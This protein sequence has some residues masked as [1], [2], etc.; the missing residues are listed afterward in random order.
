MADKESERKYWTRQDELREER[1]QFVHDAV[2]VGFT[3]EQARFL[4]DKVKSD[5]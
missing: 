4:W 2:T 5:E 3:E 1:I